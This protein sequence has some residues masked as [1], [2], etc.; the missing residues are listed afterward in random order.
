[1]KA[2]SSGDEAAFSVCMG[3]CRVSRL[4]SS[5]GGCGGR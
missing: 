5:K 2:A 3:F 1:M 4:G